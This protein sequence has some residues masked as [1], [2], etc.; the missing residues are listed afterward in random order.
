MIDKDFADLIH[1][2]AK[3]KLGKMSTIDMNKVPAQPTDLNRVQRFFKLIEDFETDVRDYVE[4]YYPLAD[5]NFID[6]QNNPQSG[7][8]KIVVNG[9]AFYIRQVNGKPGIYNLNVWYT[10]DY[11][12]ALEF[13]DY[14]KDGE[15]SETISP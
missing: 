12:A 14:V 15:T 5:L 10:I 11:R 6:G 4:K 13:D 1:S 8:H 9:I 7:W 2:K 3:Y